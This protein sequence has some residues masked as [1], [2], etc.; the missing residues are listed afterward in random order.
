MAAA[1]KRVFD[2]AEY[3]E[4]LNNRG[5]GLV[6]ADAPGFGRHL[7][8]ANTSLGDAMKAAGLAKA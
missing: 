3:K 8:A 6:Y 2:S 1:L 7:E 5:F 4:F